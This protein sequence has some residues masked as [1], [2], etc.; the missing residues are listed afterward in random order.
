PD[1][2][3]RR[4]ADGL[5]YLADKPINAAGTGGDG[6][7]TEWLLAQRRLEIHEATLTWRDDLGGA[8]EVRLEGVEIA[9]SRQRGRH[10]AA[11]IAIPPPGLAGRIEM[12]ADVRLV[13]EGNRWRARG[14]AYAEALNADLARLREHLPVPETLRSGVGSARLWLTFAPD[15]LGEVTADLN[16]RDARVQLAADA[17]PLELASLSG[18]AIYSADAKG[19]SLAT[20]QLRF[21][22]ASGAEA[23]PGRFSVTRTAAPGPGAR[24]EFRADNI[25][26]KIAATLVDYFPLPRDLKGQVLRF[27][28]RGRIS[29]ARIAWTEGANAYSVTGRFDGLAINAVEAYPGASGLTGRIEGT[30]A[31]GSLT[32][33]S[34]GASFEASRIFPA[35]FALDE[36]DAEAR[37]RHVDGAV[38]VTI[39]KARV[40]NAD[41][42]LSFAGTWRPGPPRGECK[43]PGI[44]DLKGTLDRV[45]LKRVP[46]YLP[47]VIAPTRAYLERSL[48]GGEVHAARFELRGDLW[49]FPFGG[50]AP[51]LF[52]VEA[53][54]RNGRLVYHPDWPSVDAIEGTIRFENRSMEIRAERAAIFASRVRGAS[55]IIKELGAQPAMLAIDGDIDTTG[56]DSVRFLRESPL[57]NGPGAFSRA[58]AIEGPGRLKLHLDIPLSGREPIRVAGEYRFDG[59]TASLTRTV[60][61]R[62]MQGK[63]AFT[64]R[65]V[66]AQE[67][68]GAMFGQPATLSLSNEP[69]GRVLTAVQGRIDSAVLGVFVPAAIAQHLSGSTQW[70]ARVVSSG[71]AS[72][73][74]LTSDLVGM[75]S[76]FPA[77][78]DKP[79]G[80][81]RALTVRVANA[82]TDGEVVNATLGKDLFWRSSRAAADGGPWR[83]AVKA[84]APLGE[85]PMRGGLWLHGAID[86]I[87]ADAWAAVF[88]D[89]PAARAEEARGLQGFA[90]QGVDMR[91]G[92]I[93]Y[94]G[95]EFTQTAVKLEQTG[96]TWRGT[97]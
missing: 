26:L 86:S 33:A 11:L 1:L 77:P 7:F 5:I 30:E 47:N 88:A 93:R 34:R 51:G 12:R 36:L 60:A 48:Y 70:N 13:R 61:M 92:R 40:A 73:L 22:L 14:Q 6:A 35:P 75:A 45:V 32:L 2:V 28:P 95:R 39:D 15:G 62:E 71:Q 68:T 64:E 83:V 85:E 55:A 50:E 81:A 29:D 18:R 8:P 44:V 74:T 53:R 57:V 69:D 97:L 82:G 43:S 17:L 87:D 94:K 20:E 31:G 89:A 67:L 78:L 49:E 42:A 27:A 37:W 91:F 24:V 65:G 16:M 90:L 10:H 79:A 19:F 80:S 4:G 72:E 3:L 9:L 59:A 46:A 84:G 96:T 38:E 66:S 21:R 54:V 23:S 52:L 76:S 63:L 56:A 25:D 58:I 41:G